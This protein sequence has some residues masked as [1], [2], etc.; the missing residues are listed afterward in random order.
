MTTFIAITVKCARCGVESQHEHLGSVSSSGYPDLDG[1]PPPRRRDTMSSWLQECPDCLY[2]ARDLSVA[3]TAEADAVREIGFIEAGLSE[4][5]PD[6]ATRFMRRAYIDART[7]NL[8][9]AVRRLLH[10]AWVLDDFEMNATAIRRRAADVILSLR[11]AAD[12]DLRL[13]RLDLLRRTQAFKEAI[14]E[15][16]NMLRDLSDPDHRKVALAQRRAAAEKRSTALSLSEALRPSP[17]SGRR[18][19]VTFVRR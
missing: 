11:E 17:R 2:V 19:V 4:G 10:A 3:S 13:L 12:L 6:L 5:M 16:D 1:R 14:L 9:D 15:A 7:G 18:R 8:R